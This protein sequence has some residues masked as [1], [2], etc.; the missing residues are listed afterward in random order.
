MLFVINDSKPLNKAA[1][2][3]NLKAWSSKSW[4][5]PVVAD[6]DVSMV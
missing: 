6:N 3:L 4:T 2:R 5:I 1:Q